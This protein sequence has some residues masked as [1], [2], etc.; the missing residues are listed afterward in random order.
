MINIFYNDVANRIFILSFAKIIFN[1]FSGITNQWRTFWFWPSN[2]FKWVSIRTNVFMMND[3]IFYYIKIWLKK[4]IKESEKERKRTLSRDALICKGLF[5]N[6][7]KLTLETLI[8]SFREE[9]HGL[10][11]AFWR[12]QESLSF[13][14]F[15]Q[16]TQEQF[17]TSGHFRYHRLPR[18][19]SVVQLQIVM[20]HTFFVTWNVTLIIARVMIVDINRIFP[21]MIIK[22]FHWTITLER[23]TCQHLCY[24]VSRPVNRIFAHKRNKLRATTLRLNVSRSLYSDTNKTPSQWKQNVSMPADMIRYFHR[25]VSIVSV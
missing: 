3:M 24:R 1:L 8:I 21:S 2:S 17:V 23:T 13:W 10:C 19:W 12:F 7:M 11:G 22:D 14:V 18:G 9:E 25:T 5:N 15:A 16:R 6:I 20:E 4:Y